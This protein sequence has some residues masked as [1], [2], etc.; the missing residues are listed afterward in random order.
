MGHLTPAYSSYTSPSSV[1]LSFIWTLLTRTQQS[2]SFQGLLSAFCL[3]DR[4]NNALHQL[5]KH[6]ELELLFKTLSKQVKELVNEAENTVCG[7]HYHRVSHCMGWSSKVRFPDATQPIL[8]F[9]W[10]NVQV[11]K[12]PLSVLS[13]AKLWT[14]HWNPALYHHWAK[15]LWIS[16]CHAAI[17]LPLNRLLGV[18]WY[19]ILALKWLPWQFLLCLYLGQKYQRRN[20]E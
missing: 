16:T 13:L 5:S 6:K 11:G 20:D 14:L 8:H 15:I 9:R 4:K 2:L 12:D 3:T 7:I 18:C 10:P 19:L 1:M 17:A